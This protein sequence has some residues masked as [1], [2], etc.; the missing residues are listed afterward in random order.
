MSSN[1]GTS[2]TS[3]STGPML[4]R[5]KGNEK[6]T[7]GVVVGMIMGLGFAMGL[8]I[9]LYNWRNATAVKVALSSQ[10]AVSSRPRPKLG[11]EDDIASHF[12]DPDIDPENG[13][14]LSPRALGIGLAVSGVKPQGRTSIAAIRTEPPKDEEKLDAL[15]PN[16]DV[17]ETGLLT[18]RAL[19]IGV[20]A[21]PQGRISIAAAALVAA[22]AASTQAEATSG[23]II[24]SATDTRVRSSGRS[25]FAFANL[26]R[27]LPG[28][29]DVIPPLSRLSTIPTPPSSPS[30]RH[31][32]GG[33][34]PSKQQQQPKSVFAAMHKAHQK[35]PPVI[36]LDSAS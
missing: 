7:V 16:P 32:V 24:P 13:D 8:F 12:D 36:Q 11:E 17:D 18:E 34:G 19:G 22:E 31:S 20:D 29:E 1:N 23:D 6:E 10:E 5:S 21:R 2:N 33:P 15:Y 26:R 3:N 25:S 27:G 14:A 30:R 28:A 35:P 9:F 4:F